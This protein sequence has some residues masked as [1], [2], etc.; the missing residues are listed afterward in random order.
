VL[1]LIWE[2]FLSLYIMGANIG[3][4]SEVE[5]YAGNRIVPQANH[6]KSVPESQYFDADALRNGTLSLRDAWIIA[7]SLDAQNGLES[8]GDSNKKS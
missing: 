6:Q 8:I 1:Q 7:T 4:G 5:D 2:D 3:L